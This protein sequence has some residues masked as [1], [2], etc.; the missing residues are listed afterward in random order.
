MLLLVTP[1]VGIHGHH[2]VGEGGA[3]HMQG[4]YV[5]EDNIHQFFEVIQVITLHMNTPL[6]TESCH[7]KVLDAKS[8]E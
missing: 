3:S 4:M 5:R 1:L 8:M 6:I 2:L 7:M